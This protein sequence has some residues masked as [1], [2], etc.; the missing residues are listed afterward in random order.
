[1]LIIFLLVEFHHYIIHFV[2]IMLDKYCMNQNN[3][4]YIVRLFRDD[5]VSTISSSATALYVDPV[6]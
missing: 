5:P 4:A 1:M 3:Y 6:A 2:Y